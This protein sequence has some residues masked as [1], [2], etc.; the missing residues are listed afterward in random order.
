MDYGCLDGLMQ[1]VTDVFICMQSTAYLA[2]RFT[3]PRPLVQQEVE[4]I[5]T[6]ERR[7]APGCDLFAAPCFGQ[8]AR[9]GEALQVWEGAKDTC[10]CTRMKSM[11]TPTQC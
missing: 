1:V 6:G 3:A 8:L 5:R 10:T 9:C 7:G 2:R 11:G 4:R